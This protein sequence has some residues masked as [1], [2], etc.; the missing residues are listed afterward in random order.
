MDEA[1]SSL[2]SASEFLVNRTISSIVTDRSI[3]VWIIAHRLSTIKSAIVEA[4]TFDQL[5]RPGTRFRD[6]MAAQLTP[7]K[8]TPAIP[9]QAASRDAPHART[10]STQSAPPPNG[11]IDWAVEEDILSSSTRQ[12]ISDARIQGL[13]VAAGL[14]KPDSSRSGTFTERQLYQI[15]ESVRHDG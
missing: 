10:Y 8:R 4:G 2:D 11:I 1:T 9:L 12:Q 3:T 15:V 13:H 7:A 5:N 6:L 14:P